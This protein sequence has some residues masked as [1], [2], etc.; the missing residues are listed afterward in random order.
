MVKSDKNYKNLLYYWDTC[1]FLAWIQ[2]E[3]NRT[4]EEKAGLADIALKIHKNEARL[5]TSGITKGEILKSTLSKD[6]I[7]KLDALFKRKNF[8]WVQTELR[9]YDIMHDIRDYYQKIKDTENLPTVTQADSIHL[10]SAIW[11]EADEFHTF[12]ENDKKRK[13]RALLPLSGNVAG[14]YNLVIKKPGL[15]QQSLGLI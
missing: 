12:D 14:K 15:A 6:G 9:V 1:V 8:D 10:A 3:D 4:P 2:D 7:E 11:I 5:V 13:R